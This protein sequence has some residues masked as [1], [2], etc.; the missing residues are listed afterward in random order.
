M[1][2]FTDRSLDELIAK[3]LVEVEDDDRGLERAWP[4]IEELWRRGTREVFHRACALVESATPALRGLGCAVLARLGSPERPYREESVPVVLNLAQVE[5][6]PRVLVWAVYALDGLEDVRARQVLLH[7]RGHGDPKVRLGVA[8]ALPDCIERNDDG[9]LDDREA[10]SAMLELTRD[11]DDDVRNWATFAVGQ[12][13]V[14]DTAE[15]RQA[16][17]ERLEDP[18]DETREE[19]ICGLARR[20]DEHALEPLSALMGAK[21]VRATFI[22]AAKEMA[23][24]R[25]IEALERQLVMVQER[26]AKVNEALQ[27]CRISGR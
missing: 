25:L 17:V 14:E 9:E 27:R 21:E 16:L 3:A 20:R 18:H 11:A 5:T 19:A 8:L 7:L 13:F 10:L 24:P 26:L 4:A 2:S 23:D 1:Q 6:D 15:V 12:H 22:E